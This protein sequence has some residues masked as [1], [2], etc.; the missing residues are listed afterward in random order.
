MVEEQTATDPTEFDAIYKDA[1]DEI[2]LA[3]EAYESYLKDPETI[4]FVRIKKELGFERFSMHSS[5]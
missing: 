1:E 2:R 5:L 3:E 4:S